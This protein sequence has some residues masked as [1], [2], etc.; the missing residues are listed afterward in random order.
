MWV[1][2]YGDVIENLRDFKIN[3]LIFLYNLDL[4]NFLI[5]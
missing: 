4:W 1:L 2:V 3:T 5:V